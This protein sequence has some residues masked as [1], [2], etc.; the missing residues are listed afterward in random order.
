N[1]HQADVA[2][3]TGRLV[4]QPGM[5]YDASS[6]HELAITL[7]RHLSRSGATDQALARTAGHS[8]GGAAGA[9]TAPSTNSASKVPG[10][11][12]EAFGALRT[13]TT[14]AA[15]LRQGAGLPRS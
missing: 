12:S 10:G 4:H 6:V 9:G 1:R 14:P 15:C 11:T 13:P 2:P 7:A 8:G 5:N 3:T